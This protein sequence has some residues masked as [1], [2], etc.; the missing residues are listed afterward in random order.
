MKYIIIVDSSLEQPDVSLQQQQG[1]IG[2]TKCVILYFETV[3]AVGAE[4]DKRDI[5]KHK[6]ETVFFLLP[7][8]FH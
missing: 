5:F 4:G 3:A 1:I 7:H 2:L 6:M 8:G